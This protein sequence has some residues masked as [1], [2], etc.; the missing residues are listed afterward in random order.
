MNDKNLITLTNVK[1]LYNELSINDQGTN[2]LEL[3]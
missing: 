1:M 2:L 3:D